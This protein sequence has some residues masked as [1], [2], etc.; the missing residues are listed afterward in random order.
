[1]EEE[2]RMA[3]PCLQELTVADRQLLGVFGNTIHLNDGTH[4]DGGISAAE[5]A[6]WQRLHHRVTSCSLP[7][8]DLPNGQWAHRFLTTLAD[9]WVSVL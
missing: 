1:M 8:Y 2:L 3:D 4:L 7:L 5:N 9:L 6:K